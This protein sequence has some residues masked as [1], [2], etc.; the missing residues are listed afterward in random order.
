MARWMLAV[1]SMFAATPALAGSISA[2][3][4]I[5]GVD[6]GAAT[7]NPAALHYNPAAIAA[8]DGLDVMIDTQ[9]AIVRVDVE[10]TRNGGI[11]PNTGK[12]YDLAMARKLVPVGIVGIT[13]QAIEDRLTFGLGVTDS[14]V[15]GGDYTSSENNP[16]PYTS[17]QRYHIIDTAIITATFTAGAGVTIVDGFHV[18]GGAQYVMDS[19]SIHRASDP[20]GTEGVPAA[21]L[22]MEVPDN[23][24]SDDIYL[25]GKAGGHHFG[26]NAGI[27][28]DK[29]KEFQFGISYTSGG[30]FS[31]EGEG[32]VEAP[33]T[34]GGV[35]VPSKLGVDMK[36]PPVIRANVK[37]Q[38]SDKVSV[39]AGIEY[40]LWNVCCGDEEGDILLRITN[41]N[42]DELG[43][44]D[45]LGLSVSSENYAPRRLWNAM[46]L[47]GTT[48]LQANDKLWAGLRVNYNQYAVPDYAVNPTNLDF[49]NVGAM[50]G[51]RYNV[52]GPVHLGL[53][54]SK[55]LLFTRDVETA[56]NLQD[57]NERFSPEYP[58]LTSG[59]GV[60]SG[61]VDIIGF[62][63][64]ID[65]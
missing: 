63:L 37:S 27:F 34:W 25:T 53:A 47:S 45:G 28:I 11:D 50:I 17:H 19:I 29:V 3:G 59:D 33:P 57:G 7:P 21:E 38:V 54:Y 22:A 51:G 49:A 15:G 1:S 65:S 58:F 39:G 36:L 35:T 31:T 9:L 14:F 2:P 44:D 48:G 26:W 16:P 4:V 43:P 30:T 60:Y 12:P 62:Q 13:Y 52:G 5:G 61:A 64:Q 10:A 40:Q 32:E 20:L 18:G 56:W 8:S 24:Y 23:P 41:E 55:F 46:N 6:S 42:G